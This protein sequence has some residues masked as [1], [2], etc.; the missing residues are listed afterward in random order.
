M[1][2]ESTKGDGKYDKRTVFWDKATFTSGIAVGFGGVW[3]GSPPNL[4]FI[5]VNGDELKPAGEPQ[6]LLDGWGNEDTHETLN[7]FIWGPD[8][9]LYGTQGIFTESNVGKPGTPNS[10]RTRINGGVW[11]YHPTRH[12]FERWVEGVSNQWGLDW[13][14]H[15]EAFFAAC[16]VPHM[17][18][19]IEGGHYLRQAGADLNPHFYELHPDDRMGPLRKGRLL[20]RDDLPRRR[21]PRGVARQVFLPRHPHEQDA[22]RAVRPRGLGFP[23]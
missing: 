20:R 4:L 1:V 17:W 16:V 14:D 12:V 15:G 13:N 5:P 22:L 18:H 6:K 3:L 10:E 7:D 9:W 23:Q 21:V 19:A 2:F 11:R 8:G